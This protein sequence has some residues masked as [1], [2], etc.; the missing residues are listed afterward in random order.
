MFLVIHYLC[1][2]ICISTIFSVKKYNF[3]GLDNSF[4]LVGEKKNIFQN[5]K[6]NLYILLSVRHK[7]K[8]FLMYFIYC[9]TLNVL[10][11]ICKHSR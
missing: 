2:V 10:I 11:K 9:A 6:K 3:F 7:K 1:N 4:L 5:E 8:I